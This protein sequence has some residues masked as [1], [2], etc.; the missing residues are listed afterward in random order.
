[1]TCSFEIPG[2]MGYIVERDTIEEFGT[3]RLNMSPWV[4]VSGFQDLGFR[5]YI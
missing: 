5:V 2:N 3:A 1:M 4:R